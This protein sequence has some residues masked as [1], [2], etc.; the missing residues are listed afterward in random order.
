M[1]DGSLAVVAAVAVGGCSVVTGGSVVGPVAVVG[2]SV[3]TGGSV[4]GP[5]A[6]VGGSV[7]TG[8]SVVG[9]VVAGVLAVVGG[10]GQGVPLRGRAV[11]NRGIQQLIVRSHAYSVY[12]GSLK[13]A[14]SLRKKVVP[15]A[16][17]PK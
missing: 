1:T 7:V 8:G 4:V 17:P 9:P 12:C 5:V 6:V 3:V 2:G 11:E 10:S 14:T 15:T 16:V 13:K